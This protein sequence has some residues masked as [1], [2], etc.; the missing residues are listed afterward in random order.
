MASFP[1]FWVVRFSDL[2]SYIW[3]W[4]SVKKNFGGSSK[5]KAPQTFWGKIL[6]FEMVWLIGCTVIHLQTEESLY[7][8]W[9]TLES[10]LTELSLFLSQGYA[11]T[12]CSC[13]QL[14]QSFFLPHCCCFS[15]TQPKTGFCMVGC[16]PWWVLP[17]QLASNENDLLKGNILLSSTSPHKWAHFYE[18][19]SGS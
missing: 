6:L 9:T 13:V 3:S 8:G 11:H 15:N 1:N 4:L 17:L 16:P 14:Q 18:L 12:H 10:F 19:R 2:K 7:S 5:S